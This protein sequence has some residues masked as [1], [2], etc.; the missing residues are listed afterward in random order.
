M[1]PSGGSS[2]FSTTNIQIVTAVAAGMFAVLIISSLVIVIYCVIKH[3]KNTSTLYPSTCNSEEDY[4]YIDITKGTALSKD[5]N[6]AK[7]SDNNAKSSDKDE[8]YENPMPSPGRTSHNDYKKPASFP[9]TKINDAYG[10]VN[11]NNS[12]NFP[13][14][15]ANPAYESIQTGY[16]DVVEDDIHSSADEL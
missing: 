8:L 1:A 5:Y 13:E 10:V 11:N 12:G 15:D 6:N 4:I 7:S 3:K 14:M 9:M 16:G 2:G